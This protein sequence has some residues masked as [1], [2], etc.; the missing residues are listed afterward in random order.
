VEFLKEAYGHTRKD[1]AVGVN[2]QS[3]TQYAQDLEVN[4]A[5]LLERFKSGRYVAPP[6]RRV[7]IP[8]GDGRKTRPIGIPGS[9]TRFFNA[10]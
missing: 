10:R 6:V 2:G 3:G 4:L 7:R 5:D 9:K 8:K 1:G